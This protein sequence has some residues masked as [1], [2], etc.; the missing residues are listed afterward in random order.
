MSLN[1]GSTPANPPWPLHQVNSI[2]WSQL[3]SLKF[4]LY[5]SGIYP[6]SIILATAAGY[7]T[8]IFDS[9]FSYQPLSI[10]T[11]LYL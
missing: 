7:L 1:F 9:I 5:I 11:L 10:Y 2:V 3:S 6:I 4:K 8:P